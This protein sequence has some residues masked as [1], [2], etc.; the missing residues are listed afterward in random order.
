MNQYHHVRRVADSQREFLQGVIDFYRAQT[1]TKML[2]AAERLAV[3]AA[4]TLP[5]TAISSV[6]GMNVIANAD[7]DFVLAPVLIAVMVA[8]SAVLL[9]WTRRTGTCEMERRGVGSVSAEA[10]LAAGD[11]GRKHQQIRADRTT[12]PGTSRP[13]AMILLRGPA[14]GAHRSPRLRCGGARGA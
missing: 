1:E 14:S 7:T 3:I 8:I 9:A 4:V 12:E 11:A 13:I 2:I 10:L 5:V 6:L